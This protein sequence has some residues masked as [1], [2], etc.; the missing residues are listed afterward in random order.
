MQQKLEVKAARKNNV[1]ERT[2]K[3]TMWKDDQETKHKVRALQNNVAK[4]HCESIA[5]EF[6]R[7]C[8]RDEGK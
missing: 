4:Q 5:K 8:R 1:N 3:Q 6:K 7:K 2:K